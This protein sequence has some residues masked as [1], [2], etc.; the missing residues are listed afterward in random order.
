MKNL[1][2]LLSALPEYAKDTKINLQK[3]VN[4]ENQ[5]LTIKQIF[6]IALASAY[7]LQNKNMIQALESEVKE[8]LSE[9]EMRAAKIAAT[10]MAMNNIYYRF[11]HLVEDQEYLQLPA[12]LRMASMSNSGVENIDFE[13]ISLGISAIEGCGMCIS[14]HAKHLQKLGLSKSQIQEIIK[15]AAALVSASQA[16][17][18]G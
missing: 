7:K 5:T 8:I 1:N 18:I 2:E 4:T 9:Q 11:T 10:M 12:G 14:S 15:I 3:L 13:I 16:L 6:L 17:N